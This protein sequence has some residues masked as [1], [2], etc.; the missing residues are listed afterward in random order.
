LRHV[1]RNCCH[2][3]L[4]V[5]FQIYRCPWFLFVHLALE[6]SSEEEV[7]RLGTL[8]P[9]NI[10]VLTKYP[11]SQD[12][13]VVFEIHLHSKSPMLYRPAFHGNWNALSL[14]SRR[15]RTNSPRQR[16][17]SQL[18]CKIVRYFCRILHLPMILLMLFAWWH[19]D[20]SP[21]VVQIIG[22]FSCSRLQLSKPWILWLHVGQTIVMWRL[23]AV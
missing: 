8:I 2:F 19:E 5:L 15:S 3:F 12:R 7:L 17:Y 1:G 21:D 22:S 11:L 16:F 6:I 14:A 10:E 13:I 23:F 4:D 18:F 9:M 20:W